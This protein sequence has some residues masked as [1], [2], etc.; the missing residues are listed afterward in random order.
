[1]VLPASAISA[2]RESASSRSCSSVSVRKTRTFRSAPTLS[3]CSTAIFMEG[4]LLASPRSGVSASTDSPAASK[5]FSLLSMENARSE[6]SAEPQTIIRACMSLLMFARSFQGITPLTS[7]TIRSPPRAWPTTPDIFLALMKPADSGLSSM[8]C[9]STPSPK[10]QSARQTPSL[11][12]SCPGMTSTTSPIDA[13]ASS[14]SGLK[15]S[16]GLCCAR[17]LTT[18]F[19]RSSSLSLSPNMRCRR[20]AE[21]KSVCEGEVQKTLEGAWL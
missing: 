3:S 14:C 2:S 15:E 19:L 20:S 6:S 1:M 8:I 5:E 4:D 11:M 16:K 7:A 18:R 17:K 12:T 9:A 13:M 21:S 10:M